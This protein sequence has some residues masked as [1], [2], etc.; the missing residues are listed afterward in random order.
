[1]TILSIRRFSSYRRHSRPCAPMLY[2][3]SWQASCPQAVTWPP[4]GRWR[5]PA[6]LNE[7]SGGF[8]R[9][10]F[11]KRQLAG[12]IEIQNLAQPVFACL[13]LCEVPAKG[14]GF[15]GLRDKVRK[16]RAVEPEVHSLDDQVVN[17]GEVAFDA[18][19]ADNARCE[20]SRRTA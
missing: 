1:M 15:L 17:G 18:A 19:A 9:P 13:V 8:G 16:R 5:V 2:E 11:V 3:S 6:S 4:P 10:V 20:R 7:P 12:R 14:A